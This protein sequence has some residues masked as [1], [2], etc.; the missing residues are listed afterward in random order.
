MFVS[1]K[2]LVF[3]V[4]IAGFA[5]GCG[6]MSMDHDGGMDMSSDGGISLKGA[7]AVTADTVYVVNGGSNSLSLLNAQTGSVEGTLELQG[8]QF[9]HHVSLSPDRSM[10]ALAVPG[11]D[12]SA[13]HEGMGGMGMKGA[14]LV[15]DAKTG[16]AMASRQFDAMN[17]NAIFSPDG[18]E[19]W[20]SQM[21]MPGSVL[22]LKADD[23]STIKTITVG[24][25]PAEVT[26]S[27]DGLRAFVANSGSNSVSVIDAATK[28]VIM[29]V[30]VG[31][32]PV[33]AWA[34]AN[35]VMYVDNEMGKSITAIDAQSLSVLRTYALG[36]T[37]GMVATGPGSELWVTD[38]DN[39]R[40]VI[41]MTDMD[42]KTGEIATG[43]GA[44]GIAFSKDK[45]SAW[46]TNQGAG[47][48]SVID[49]GA[50]T[51]KQ[52]VTVG[53]KPNGLLFRPAN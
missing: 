32:N 28:A 48:V 9:P 24:D 36:F 37:P 12:L 8:G 33:G 23:L 44:H 52:T 40:V 7:A 3:G 41:N 13:G 39:G 53:Q 19:L 35:N 21:A 2:H 30:A 4:V 43:A 1:K 38:A 10:V 22:V 50:K 31:E 17:H 29:N 34:G 20:T 49:V 11:M 42:M 25:M 6:G 15:F 45:S 26:F 27:A 47:T 16:A 46:V 14:L 5:S 18:K 51:V